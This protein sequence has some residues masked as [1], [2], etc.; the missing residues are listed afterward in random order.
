MFYLRI[1]KSFSRNGGFQFTQIPISML[2]V[3]LKYLCLK[4]R[5]N[6]EMKC[7]EYASRKI[8][9]GTS[10]VKITFE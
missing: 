4:W 3:F 5:K 7:K 1:N 9:E 8:N 10:L 2:K 6:T